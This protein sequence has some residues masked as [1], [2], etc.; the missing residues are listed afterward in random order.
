[1][2]FIQEFKAFIQRGNVM[3]LAVAVIMGAAFTTIVNSL[4]TDVFTPML[5]IAT[6]GNDAFSGLDIKLN[7]D[8]TIKIGSFVKA[9]FNFFVISFCVF[10]IVKGVN[11][12]Y[13]QKLLAG[14]PKPVEL[15]TQ[16]KL[17]TEIRDLLK[18]KP[19]VGAVKIEGAF[20]AEKK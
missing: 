3:D 18:E 13:L 16:E 20:T 10:L 17:L 1:M 15:T 14:A 9:I 2:N 7:N 6:Q 4:V 11:A 5:G 19:D 12:L 8:A